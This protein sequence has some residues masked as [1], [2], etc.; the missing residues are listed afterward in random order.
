MDHI[1]ADFLAFAPVANSI[2]GDCSHTNHSS[3]PGAGIF[4]IDLGALGILYHQGSGGGSV[5]Q[6]LTVGLGH[7]DFIAGGVLHL[8][9]TDLEPVSQRCHRSGMVETGFSSDG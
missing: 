1:A 8:I 2:V 5:G 6:N 3:S 4:D 9:P 7:F